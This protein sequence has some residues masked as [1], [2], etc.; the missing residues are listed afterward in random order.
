[1]IGAIR[2][3]AIAPSAADSPKRDEAA[4]AHVD[5]DQLRREPVVRGREHRL[6]EAACG[7]RT[8]Q[9]ASTIASVT[10]STHRLCGR[11]VAPTIAIGRSPEN[12]GSA[13][14]FLSQTSVA[15]PRRK[16]DAPMVMMIS[17]TT[18][19]P[20]AGSTANFSSA[21]PTSAAA[22]TAS[23][24]ASGER[25][26]GGD[27]RDRAHAADHHELALGEVDDV[28]RVEDDREAERD[29]RVDR[30]D[31]QPGRRYW[32]SSRSLD[33][34]RAPRS[35]F[36]HGAARRAHGQRLAPAVTSPASSRP[37]APRA[38]GTR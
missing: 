12:G 21:S 38:C 28:A 23:G 18:G 11:S 5:A 15:R 27:E 30:A 1:M 37:C 26:A 9:S 35:G 16:I 33:Y 29:Q 34:P 17:V 6:A 2:M 19:A 20:R 36:A 3:P 7:R 25:Q 31:G 8:T 10:P 22:T 14:S 13:C 32:A 24:I 4:R